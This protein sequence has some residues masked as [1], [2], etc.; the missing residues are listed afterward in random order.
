MMNFQQAMSSASLGEMWP[1]EQYE[2]K[3]IAHA[4]YARAY[5]IRGAKAESAEQAAYYREQAAIHEA[6]SLTSLPWVI[7]DGGDQRQGDERFAS[8][9][10]AWAFIDAK[11]AAGEPY[12]Y[13][14][15]A[16]AYEFD[17]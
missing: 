5:S 7:A 1:I 15:V 2:N 3:A 10:D 6:K 17:L 14:R 4:A 11:C 16:P 13:S 12:Q 8:T 9:E